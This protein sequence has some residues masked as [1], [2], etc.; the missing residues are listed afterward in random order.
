VGESAWFLRAWRYNLR[1]KTFPRLIPSART[2]AS[3][4]GEARYLSAL[5]AKKERDSSSLPLLCSG[6]A[7]PRNGTFKGFFARTEARP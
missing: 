4:R 5:N 6:Q 1:K 7:A 3:R 2:E